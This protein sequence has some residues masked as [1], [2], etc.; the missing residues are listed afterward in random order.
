[1]RA[2]VFDPFAGISGDMTLGA[3]LDLGLPVEWFRGFV[4]GLKLGDL[5]VDA[6][7]AERGAIACTRLVLRL[8]EEHAH[9][10]LKDVVRI[11]ESTGVSVG[12]RE[13]AVRAFT[14]LA[15]AEAAV[16]GTTPERVHFHEVGA[17]DA[18]VDIL[19]VMAACEELGVERFYTRPVTL[20][21]GWAEMAH[22]RFP[23][24][25]PAVLKLLEGIP[26]RD[27]DFEGEC[28]TPT[29]AVI[30]RTLT[31][32]DPPPATF[33]PLATGFGAGSRDPRDRPNCLRLVLIEEGHGAEEELELL[34]TDVDDMPPEYVPPLQQELLRAG[35][36]DCVVVPVLMKKG[37]PGYRVEALVRATE[38]RAVREALFATS[39]SIGIRGWT[40]TRA[41]LP[42]REAQSEWRGQTIR[43][44]RSSLPDGSE[45]AKPEFE[46]VV[47]AAAALGIP[48]YAAYRAMLAEG[49]AADE[50]SERPEDRG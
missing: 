4:R 41:A 45:R 13:K 27:P 29:G 1:M 50:G 3:L 21:R 18:I 5:E 7:R 49:V 15:E 11:I 47:R 16:H 42:R 10:H 36:L 48:P 19:G 35:A 26:V 34:Q 32:G 33:V 9:R 46:D 22:G 25:P 31:G 2:L 38:A 12:V 37:R 39:S 8:P 17:L 24:P 43:V 40:V 23:V 14:L 28:T 20:G 44:K 30:I 6:E